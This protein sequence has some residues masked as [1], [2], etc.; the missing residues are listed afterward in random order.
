MTM[1]RSLLRV[2]AAV[3]FAAVAAPSGTPSA[4]PVPGLAYDEIVRVLVGATP[5]P[6]GNF[7]TDLAAVNASPEP[8]VSAAPKRRGFGLG[9]IAGTILNGGGAGAIG[10][11]I[12]GE[13]MSTAADNALSQTLGNSFAGLAATMRSF[14]APHVLHY[15]YWNGWERIDDTTAQTATI[16]KCDIG[17]VVHLDLAKKTYAIYDPASEP[18][19]APSR[20]APGP[21]PARSTPPQP[22]GTAVIDV[23]LTTRS[24]GAL[25][26]ESQP[27]SGYDATAAFAIT[28]STGSCR[29]ARSSIDTTSYYT[30]LTRP[31]VTSCPVQRPPVPVSAADAMAPPPG[32]GGCRPTFTM[33]HSG[34]PEPA[35][36]LAAY[37]LVTMTAS[38]VATPAPASSAMP[39]GIGFLTERGNFATLG[40][41]N[42]NQFDIPPGFTLAQSVP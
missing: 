20:P 8:F 35:G 39:G 38:T 5:P 4:A 9:A 21:R 31:S 41:A 19:A 6:P 10:G 34:P 29:D 22:P 12:A 37:A 11:A 1:W 14:L 32:N 23:S 27:T 17:R 2:G 28:Q 15:A 3:A 18:T 7:Q 36:K 25:R 13:A 26:I 33:H 42:S 30:G 40:A 24:L 16:R